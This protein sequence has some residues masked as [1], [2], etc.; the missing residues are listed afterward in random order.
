[1]TTLLVCGR[2]VILKD[3]SHAV[4]ALSATGFVVRP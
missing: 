3:I 2:N 4:Y 1:M